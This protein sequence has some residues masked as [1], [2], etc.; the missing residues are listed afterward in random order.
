[1]VADDELFLLLEQATAT[2]ST[3]TATATSLRVLSM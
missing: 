3:A 1:V 2:R